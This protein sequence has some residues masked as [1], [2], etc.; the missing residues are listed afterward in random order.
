MADHRTCKEVN[1][2]SRDIQYVDPYLI[3][4][5]LEQNTKYGK[6]MLVEN[7]YNLTGHVY[8]RVCE[9]GTNDGG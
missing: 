2:K 1:G 4:P 6:K 3:C 8:Q 5:F 7:M 9:V